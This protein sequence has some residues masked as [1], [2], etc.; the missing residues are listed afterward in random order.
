MFT[1]E[2][3]RSTHADECGSTSNAHI[4]QQSIGNFDSP[5]PSVTCINVGQKTTGGLLESAL[6]SSREYKRLRH[7]SSSLSRSASGIACGADASYFMMKGFKH[8]RNGGMKLVQSR[9]CYA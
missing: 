9:G 6:N 5:V 2:N 7:S 1:S 3:T 8:L 4:S